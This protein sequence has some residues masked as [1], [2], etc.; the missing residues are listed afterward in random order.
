MNVRTSFHPL[1]ERELND[2]ARF[3]EATSPGL[4]RAF[5]VE[6]EHCLREVMKHPGSGTRVRNEI[7]RRLFRRFPYGLL[8][9]IQEGEVRV[10]AVTNLKRRPFYWAPRE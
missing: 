3:Y 5:L 2:A 6:A 4:G 10:V 9:R 7:R 8:Y 1:A